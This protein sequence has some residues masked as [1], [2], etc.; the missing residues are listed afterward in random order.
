MNVMDAPMEALFMATTMRIH[1]ADYYKCIKWNM[2]L[3]EAWGD[4]C[5]RLVQIARLGIQGRGHHL[6]RSCRTAMGA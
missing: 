2:S 4:E 5:L 1:I 3:L 6:K